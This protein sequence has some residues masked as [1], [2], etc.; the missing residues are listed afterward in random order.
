[1]SARRS[2]LLALA[3]GIGAAVAAC[4][5][6]PGASPAPPP[7]ARCD[8]G[9]ELEPKECALVH[10]LRL[11]ASLEP[12]RGN[13]FAESLDAAAFGMNVFYDARF[14]GTSD[15]RCATCHDPEYAFTGRKAPIEAT[16]PRNSP[17]VLDAMSSRWLF[18]DGRADS[19]WSQALG[20]FENA[21]EM[22]SSR[23]RIVHLIA[24][25]YRAQYE[26]LFGALPPLDD[27]TRFPADGKPDDA[28][29]AVMAPADRVLVDTVFVNVGKSIEAFERRVTGGPSSFDAF[30]DGDLG[31]LDDDA[32]R[33]L[34][35]MVRSGCLDCHSGPRFTD[36]AFHDLG[37]DDL[38]PASALGR[39]G[40]VAKLLASE[41]N[42]ASA[43]YDGEKPLD[44]PPKESDADLGAFRTPSLRNVS[45]TG[46]WGHTGKFKTLEDVIDFHLRGGGRDRPDVV[47]TV[48]P[49]L[50][51]RAL[52]ATEMAQLVAFLRSLKG[53]GPPVPWNTWPSR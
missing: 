37:V 38:D 50:V 48:D 34:V 40:G 17:T 21:K 11:P 39:K 9:I 28:S 45:V 4:G 43:Y 47:G 23:L 3:L 10:A 25:N 20:P 22:G 30:L 24:K 18:W 27:L 32:K 19:G 5:G 33:G 52:D 29:W 7:P 26:A 44:F 41:F 53:S 13:R 8:L 51:P 14:S 35:V 1:M 2:G 16:L 49:L 6:E 12:A 15:V 46:P 36:G 31:A 42:S